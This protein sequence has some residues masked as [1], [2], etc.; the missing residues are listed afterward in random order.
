MF[1]KMEARLKAATKAE[2]AEVVIK[3]GKIIDVFT[4]TIYEAD[5]AITDGVIIGIGEY[6]GNEV[7][8]AKGA[9]ISPPFID[10]H[11][12]IES[13]MV[14][15]EEFARIVVPKGVTTVMADPHEIANVGGIE[16]VR[17][18]IEAAKGLPLD[19]K[20]M[21]PS[22]VPATSFENSGASLTAEEVETLFEE[23]EAYGLAE[24]MDYP[25]VF[26]AQKEMLA[27]I[28]AAKKRH[29]PIDGHA[30]GLDT[31]GINAYRVAGIE[32]DHEAVT[33]E[34]ALD[35]IRRGMYVLMREGTAAKDIEALLPILTSS[36]AR[37]CVFATDDKHLD[38]LVDEGSIDASIRKAIRLGVEPLQAIQMASLN[39]A[40]CFKLTEKGA[41]APGYE[42]SFLFIEDLQQL[43]IQSVFVKGEC[44]AQNGKLVQSLREY[45][46]PPAYLLDSVHMT[47]KK[48]SLQLKLEESQKANVIAVTPGSI[49][50][51]ALV[52]EVTVE[53]GQFVPSVKQNQLKLVVAERHHRL[54]HVG[55]GVVK[56]FPIKNGAIV[57]SIAHDSHNI[58]T[59]GTDDLSIYKAI[60]HV[61][62]LKG[63]IAVV[64]E[65]EVL[66][67]VS[68]P[69]AGLMSLES[70]STVYRT[71]SALEESLGKIG[72]D[73]KW[74]P[75]LT[76]SFLALPVIPELKLTDLGLFDV[77]SFSHIDVG[78]N[79]V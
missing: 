60:S 51:K 45:V 35:R 27:K 25:S 39:A 36:N 53:N 78:V 28:S 49:V 33:A 30:A 74:N 7:I 67:D 31:V 9:Y 50:T 72:F 40:E 21:V 17:Y 19:V 48:E 54:G 5:I 77:R 61:A 18:M 76:L 12:H 26:S 79:D 3:N 29:K 34:E 59:C 6:E 23:T 15:P 42:A 8:D 66:A 10:G 65:G 70:Y 58:V 63:G 24:V 37:R 1:A 14:P 4:L 75:F 22:S 32:N 56:G 71:L 38:D 47:L 16:A 13:A 62:E 43:T 68:L 11:V 44:V 64:S 52:E 20:V 57:A 69:L 41:I 46:A 73:E 2:K 55:V